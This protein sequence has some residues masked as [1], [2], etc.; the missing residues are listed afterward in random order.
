M[1]QGESQVR[2][3]FLFIMTTKGRDR[4]GSDFLESTGLTP[5]DFFGIIYTYH[6]QEEGI[7]DLT[8]SES[9][10]LLLS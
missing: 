6:N 8:S 1:P 9:N 5:H 7:Y 10:R 2:L 4:E 3:V